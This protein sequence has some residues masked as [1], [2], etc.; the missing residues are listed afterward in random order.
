MCRLV[1]GHKATAL[2]EVCVP[3]P[4][5]PRSVHSTGLRP[6]HTNNYYYEPYGAAFSLVALVHA[7]DRGGLW[8]KPWCRYDKICTLN[9]T[10]PG[11]TVPCLV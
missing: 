4:I 6:V 5:P 10:D 1:T 8:L 2:Q 9:C 3:P 7:W 11:G